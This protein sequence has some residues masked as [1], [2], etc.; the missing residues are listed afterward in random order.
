VV[1]HTK[2]QARFAELAPLERIDKHRGMER[3][4]A[5]GGDFESKPATTP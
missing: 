4:V 2:I 5:F 3:I 1:A